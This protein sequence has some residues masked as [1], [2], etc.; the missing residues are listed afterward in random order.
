MDKKFETLMDLY[1][2]F[3]PFKVCMK[4]LYKAHSDFLNHLN[5]DSYAK[6]NDEALEFSKGVVFSAFSL[7]YIDECNYDHFICVLFR[8]A[9]YYC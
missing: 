3:R 9:S 2:G 4:S 6:W 1:K 5:S 7:G 8:Y